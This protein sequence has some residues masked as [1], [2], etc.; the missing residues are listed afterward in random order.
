MFGLTQPKI[1]DLTQDK[2]GYD[3]RLKQ[4]PCTFRGL[5]LQEYKFVDVQNV[6][7]FFHIPE[8]F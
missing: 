7:F 8:F 5:S 4:I 3:L 6:D 2:I 1:N